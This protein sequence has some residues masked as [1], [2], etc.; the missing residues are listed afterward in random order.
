MCSRIRKFIVDD[1]DGDFLRD[2]FERRIMEAAPRTRS[3]QL[4]YH[5][6]DVHES[7]IIRF[8][9]LLHDP[10]FRFLAE[11]GG[12]LGSSEKNLS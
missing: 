9:D 7:I 11:Q 3:I 12:S 2:S 6:L 5:S 1:L 4:Y 8:P 10:L